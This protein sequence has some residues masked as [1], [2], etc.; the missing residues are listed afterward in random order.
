M[1]VSLLGCQGS[2]LALSCL[3]GVCGGSTAHPS[4]W[5]L[6]A[7]G[8]AGSNL[9]CGGNECA[10]RMV[11]LAKIAR[12]FHLGELRSYSEH[13]CKTSFSEQSIQYLTSNSSKKYFSAFKAAL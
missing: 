12:E 7:A 5:R 4:S 6:V 10:Y 11:E 13:L 1:I 2:S 8:R 3:L 9:L